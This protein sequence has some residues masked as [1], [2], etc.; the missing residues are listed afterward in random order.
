MPD[1]T[2][3]AEWKN[4]AEHATVMSQIHMRDLFADD[5]NRFEENSLHFNDILVDY[6]KN[7]TTEET[8]RLLMNLARRLLG[9]VWPWKPMTLPPQSPACKR[10]GPS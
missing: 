6:S 4:L 8:K 9:S 3:T 5:A 7:I 2:Q 10:R 1:L